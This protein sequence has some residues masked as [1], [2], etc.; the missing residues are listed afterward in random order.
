MQEVQADVERRRRDYLGAP[1]DVAEVAGD[2]I[3]QF[4]RWYREAVDAELTEPNAMMLATV[5]ERGDPQA[6]VVLLRG[7][8][9]DGFRFYT[10]YT[11]AKARELRRHPRAALTFAWLDLSRQ[12]R[13]TGSVRRLPDAVSDA[14]FAS[15]PRGSRI[16]AW[17]SPQSQVLS[18]REDLDRLVAETEARFAGIQ[19]IPRPE[20]WGGYVVAPEM[21]EF[22][23][24]RPSRLHDRLRYRRVG[25]AWV[26][27]RLAP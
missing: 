9:A 13:V 1:L 7:L 10:N 15:R 22:W 12:V 23:Q 18:G 17:A 24:G 2:P 14:Y 25:E 20:F 21:I 6:R 11:G 3:A 19:E 8:D 5:D 4:E 27:E 26:L 16:G